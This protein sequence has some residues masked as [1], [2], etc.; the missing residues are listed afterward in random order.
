MA[1]FALLAV[2]ERVSGY[3]V[4]HVRLPVPLCGNL[5]P[6][7][8]PR[9]N[10]QDFVSDFYELCSTCPGQKLLI[11]ELDTSIIYFKIEDRH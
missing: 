7:C 5:K 4:P 1:L 10:L 2:L 6:L 8:G 11:F 9:K 3:G